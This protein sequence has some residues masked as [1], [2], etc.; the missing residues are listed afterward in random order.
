MSITTC[1]HKLGFLGMVLQSSYFYPLNNGNP[2]EPPIYPVPA[3]TNANITA[4]QIT[5]VV[6]LYKDDKE[7]SSTCFEFRI[8]L[9]SMITNKCPEKYM[10]ILKHHITKFHQS[11]VRS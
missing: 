11:L 5:E 3:L 4:S 10:T 8:I 7:K 1:D 9:I 6:R 2:F